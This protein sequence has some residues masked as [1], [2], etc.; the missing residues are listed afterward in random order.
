MI[1]VRNNNMFNITKKITIKR[2]PKKYLSFPDIIKSPKT[3]N[4]LFLIYREGDSHHPVWSNLVLW[5]SNDNGETWEELCKFRSDLKQHDCVWNCPRLSYI[6]D[7]L[8]IICD[9][10]SGTKERFA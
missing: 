1:W 6:G 4:R 5:V 9:Q 7:Y 8:Y 3:N 2:D 10:Q